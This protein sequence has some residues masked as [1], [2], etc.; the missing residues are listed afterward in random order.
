M[1]EK[2][3]KGHFSF[4]LSQKDCLVCCKEAHA[5]FWGESLPPYIIFLSC[6]PRKGKLK[7]FLQLLVAI[8][9]EFI[10]VS[11]FWNVISE[12]IVIILP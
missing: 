2:F 4:F 3:Q 7:L 6:F 12:P 1:G 8:N 11:S 9:V 5:A 10:P